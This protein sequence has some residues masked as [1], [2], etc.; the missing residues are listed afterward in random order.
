MTDDSKIFTIETEE[1][2]ATKITI[3]FIPTTLAIVLLL[4]IGMFQVLAKL[5]KLENAV[6]NLHT[7]VEKVLR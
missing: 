5:D 1:K 3:W 2:P 6:D 7:D 4:L